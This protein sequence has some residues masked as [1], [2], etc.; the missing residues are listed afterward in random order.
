LPIK[1]PDRFHL[2]LLNVILG[3]GMSSRLN[4]EIR[5]KRGLAYDIHSY[6]E[7]FLDSGIVTIY[8]GV[9]LGNVA[10]TIEAIVEE[11]NHLR[12]G[13]PEEE[14]VK[15]KEMVKGRLLLSMEDTRSVAGWVGGQEILVGKV[16]SVEEV[17][18]IVDDITAQG[19][20]RVAQDIIVADKLNLAVVGPVRDADHLY[21]LLT[22]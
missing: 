12:G 9:D 3:G 21:R 20:Q 22:L 13:V 8:A 15:A 16:R 7:Y 2:D 6:V 4:L 11:L 10:E 17:L 14:Q 1:H 19:L 18:S 5:E